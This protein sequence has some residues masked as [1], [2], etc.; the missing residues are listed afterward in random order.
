MT[1]FK[2]SKKKVEE[3][4]KTLINPQGDEN[5]DS[6]FFTQFFMQSGAL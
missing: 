6:L 3:F 1:D 5:V 2:D 4:N